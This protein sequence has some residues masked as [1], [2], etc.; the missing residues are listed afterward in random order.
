MAAGRASDAD[1]DSDGVAGPSNSM[2]QQVVSAR[3]QRMMSKHNLMV[4]QSSLAAAGYGLHAATGAGLAA[5]YTLPCKGP[6]F[7]D[8]ASLQQYLSEQS[9]ENSERL[10][11]FVQMLQA[12]CVS[13]SPC[14]CIAACAVFCKRQ[15]EYVLDKD[16][17]CK[18]TCCR[19]SDMN[20]ISLARLKTRIVEIWLAPAAGSSS[21]EATLVYKVMTNLCGSGLRIASLPSGRHLLAHALFHFSRGRMMCCRVARMLFAISEAS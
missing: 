3:N 14:R 5:G 11:S 12:G 6:I 21:V 15:T 19:E 10:G 20:C 2:D 13:V 18:N 4:K 7:E 9:A 8:M 1:D 16:S 17:C